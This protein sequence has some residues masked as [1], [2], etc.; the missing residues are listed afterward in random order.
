MRRII[1]LSAIAAVVVSSAGLAQAAVVALKR[2]TGL[3][4]TSPSNKKYTDARF[5][6]AVVQVVTV[7]DATLSTAGNSKWGNYGAILTTAGD[8]SLNYA[9]YKF[10]LSSLADIAGATVNKAQLRLYHTSGNGGGTGPLAL[11]Q[12]I[13]HD[14]MEGTSSTGG[15]PGAAGGVSYAHPMGHNT[16]A[17]QNTNGGTSIPLQ[18]WGVNSD[19]FFSPAGDGANAAPIVNAGLAG[20][21]WGVFDVTTIVQNWAGGQSNFGFYQNCANWK[22][23]YSEAGTTYEPVLFI[24]YTP[25]PEPAT[26]V[27]IAL[28][29]LTLLRRRA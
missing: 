27:L 5:D 19:S 23:Q 16:S 18:S 21:D 17:S 26:L 25:T 15:Y 24:D 10:D 12:V 7:S 22:W 9:L 20:G 1:V 13:T 2:D 6:S 29:G 28:G 3:N 4:F 14:W 11:G 8:S